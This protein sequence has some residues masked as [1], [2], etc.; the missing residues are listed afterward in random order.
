MTNQSNVRSEDADSL[1]TEAELAVKNEKPEEALALYS[2]A[3]KMYESLGIHS[4]KYF[5]SLQSAGRLSYERGNPDEARSFLSAAAQA[6]REYREPTEVDGWLHSL[7][8]MAYM[9][10]DY[11]TARDLLELALEYREQVHPQTPEHAMT[12]MNLG[13]VAWKEERRSA[14]FEYFDRCLQI[15]EKN[16]APLKDID[17]IYLLLVT[18]LAEMGPEFAEKH[19]AYKMRSGELRMRLFQENFDKGVVTGD[20]IEAATR[21][22]Q[23]QDDKP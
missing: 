8:T 10:A 17:R 5:K 23:S 4:D 11:V 20:M 18:L 15:Q 21:W 9:A 16:S 22:R 2:R 12:L 3:A 7:G 13:A 1:F 14:A 19:N 6:V